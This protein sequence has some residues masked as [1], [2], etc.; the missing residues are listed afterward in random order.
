MLVSV[1]IL[2]QKI[3]KY[4]ILISILSQSWAI[5]WFW[6]RFWL[7]RIDM[8][9]VDLILTQTW[10]KCWFR[11]RFWLRLGQ[12]VGF[13]FDFDEKECDMLYVDF[14]FD[15]DLDKEL[16][17]VL[18][19]TQTGKKCWFWFRFWLITLW[20]VIC[21]FW[22]RLRHKSICCFLSWYWPKQVFMLHVDLNHDS[23]MGNMLVSVSILTKKIVNCCMLVLIL[24]QTCVVC[25][26]WFRFWLSDW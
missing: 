9:N 12:S 17:S 15:S 24:T 18:I 10:T 16:V 11:F 4:C 19:L 21:W 20:N 22:L 25:W 26:Y 3:V 7:K 8:L 1:S 23:S 13:G 2:T 14:D 5:C 6:F